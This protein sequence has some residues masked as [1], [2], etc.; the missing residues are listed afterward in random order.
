MTEPTVI[1]FNPV[2]PF[3]GDVKTFGM[4]GPIQAPMEYNGWRE[5]SLSWKESAYLGAALGMSPIYSVRG[6]DAERFFSENF[7]ND[8]T[9]MPVGGFRHGIMCDTQGRIVMDGVV[10]RIAQD[11]FYTC[12]LHH[13]DYALS[14]DSD[15]VGEN[16]T[17]RRFLFQVAAPGPW[18]SGA[19]RGTDLHDIK[20]GWHR[21]ATIA[22]AEV[23][24]F[25][26]HGR[27]AGVRVHGDVADGQ[28][29]QRYLGGGPGFGMKKLGHV[30]YMLNHTEDGFPQAYYHFPYPGT[31]TRGSR[32]TW[33]PGPAQGG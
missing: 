7:V 14:K 11:E 1:P 9:S 32:P 8:F 12:W 6:P 10:M 17:G 15:A 2:V 23:R 30:A 22:G 28:D 25:G 19:R 24:C 20:F 29:V 18:R 4:I 31:R 3:Q 5:E 21:T 27:I 13:I 16:L 33:M 26:W